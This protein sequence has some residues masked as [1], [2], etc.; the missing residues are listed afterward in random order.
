MAAAAG[1]NC[2]GGKLEF[3]IDDNQFEVDEVT[4]ND[5]RKYDLKFDPSF[6]LLKK[7][8]EDCAPS[9]AQCRAGI[10][11]HAA[12]RRHV[13]CSE[14]PTSG[15]TSNTSSPLASLSPPFAALM[16]QARLPRNMLRFK[17]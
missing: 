12:A 6:K 5:G 4:S 8:L 3:D 11:W 16:L 10:G 13:A 2:S 7:E 15:L 14:R 17:A 1:Q 9:A